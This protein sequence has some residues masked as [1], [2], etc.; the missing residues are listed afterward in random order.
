MRI[1]QDILLSQFK[2]FC[3]FSLK[4]SDLYDQYGD[5]WFPFLRIKS[6]RPN[7]SVSSAGCVITLSFI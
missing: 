6:G 2:M 7:L 3:D 1:G 5:L 4:Y